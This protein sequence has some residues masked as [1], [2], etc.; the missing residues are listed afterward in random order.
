MGA[1]VDVGGVK[2]PDRRIC[3]GVLCN[4]VDG[5]VDSYN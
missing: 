1:S 5:G 2:V 3:C 4:S